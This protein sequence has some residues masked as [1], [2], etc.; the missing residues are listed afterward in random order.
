MTH[1]LACALCSA[2]PHADT[3]W[4]WRFSNLAKVQVNLS[5]ANIL[6][7]SLLVDRFH[8]DHDGLS[9]IN[10]PQHLP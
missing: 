7:T 10:P 4:L 1:V 3:N 2:N 6:T 5:S 8:S 9:A